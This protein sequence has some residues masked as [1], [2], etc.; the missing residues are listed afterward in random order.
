[1]LKSLIKL[2]G[3]TSP[4][5]LDGL[6]L[7]YVPDY[8]ELEGDTDLPTFLRALAPLISPSACLYLEDGSPDG[9]LKEWIHRNMI[10]PTE[11]ISRGSY[12]HQGTTFHI[13]LT[14]FNIT[15]LATLSDR[16]AAPELAIHIHVYE[17][18][19]VILEWHDA[20][21]NPILIDGRVDESTV[22]EFARTIGFTYTKHQSEQGGG[23]NRLKPVPHL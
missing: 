10:H 21:D 8:W 2:F 1:M 11:Q 5:Q 20:L 18:G 22:S 17:P 6:H 23:G 7:H 15:E 13:P 16:V 19:R 9:D 14:E 3:I 4:S 12:G